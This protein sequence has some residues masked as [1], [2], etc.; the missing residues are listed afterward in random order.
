[1]SV[2]LA[3]DEPAEATLAQ[4]L[5]RV[6]S[7][8]DTITYFTTADVDPDAVRCALAYKNLLNDFADFAESNNSGEALIEAFIKG[9]AGDPFGAAADNIK[10]SDD[11]NRKWREARR[12]GDDTRSLLSARYKIGF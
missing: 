4:R 1:M 12:L 5:I 11:L 7:M 10:S 9:A 3:F 6:R 2:A 8:A